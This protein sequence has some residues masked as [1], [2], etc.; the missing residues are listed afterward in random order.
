MNNIIFMK[1]FYGSYTWF[2]DNYDDKYSLVY[3]YYAFFEHTL[4]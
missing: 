4:D 2:H 3:S 1:C